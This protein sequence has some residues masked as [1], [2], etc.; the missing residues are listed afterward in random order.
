MLTDNLEELL[1][2]LDG[3]PNLRDLIESGTIDGSEKRSP[4]ADN[5]AAQNE[6]SRGR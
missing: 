5:L 2:S 3:G 1:T 4:R 6:I